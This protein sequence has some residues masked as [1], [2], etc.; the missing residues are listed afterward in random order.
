MHFR[1]LIEESNSPLHA[2]IELFA[3]FSV[4]LDRMSEVLYLLLIWFVK[5]VSSIVC[6]KVFSKFCFLKIQAK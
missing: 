3:H 2:L 6:F 4:F 5:N 1:S